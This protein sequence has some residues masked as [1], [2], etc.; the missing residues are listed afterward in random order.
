MSIFA[1]NR[2]RSALSTT[3]DLLTITAS[4]TKPLKVLMGKLAGMDTASAA[5]EVVIQ[6]S[7]AGT[8]PSGAITPEKQDP[9]SGAASF[10]VATAWA[11]QPTLS[12]GPLHRFAPNA[13]GGID[14]YVSLPGA[15]I[16]VPVGTQISIRS[17]YGTSNV[18]AN[19]LIEEIG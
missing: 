3:A 14:P 16:F 8:T 4:A 10:T 2:T 13:N 11:V 1:V 9:G 17:N 6:R 18:T 7:T 5:N 12:G 19:F 15:E